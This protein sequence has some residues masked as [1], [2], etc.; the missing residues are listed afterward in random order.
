MSAENRSFQVKLAQSGRIIVV[1]QDKTVVEALAAVGVHVQT[2]CG[3]GICGTCLTTVLEGVPEHRDN[4]L[5]AEERE[6]NNL[7]TPCCSRAKSPMLVI[8][9]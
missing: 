8:D 3:E 2:S 4:L 6:K 7:F 9:L 5:S 1:D